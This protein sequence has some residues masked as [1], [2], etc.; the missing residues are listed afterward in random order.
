MCNVHLS[1]EPEGAAQTKGTSP[2]MAQNEPVQKYFDALL[3]SYDLMVDSIEKANDRGAK[4]SKQFTSDIVKGQ[5][6]AI[7]LGKKL[8]GEPAEVGQFYTALLEMTT[9]AQGRA[10]NFVQ[11]A[12]QEALG[13]GTDARE[14][15]QK[16]VDA[17]R[18]T[19]EAALEAARSFAGSNPFADMLQ[20][21]FNQFTQATAAP[22]A[23]ARKEKATA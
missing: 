8:A 2:P 3:A 6:E 22:R 1:T 7:E 19:A 4:V 12:Y 15:A 17:N 5:R 9:A 23:T 21:G 11:A 14:T 16:L 18:V 10:M 20:Q 13:A